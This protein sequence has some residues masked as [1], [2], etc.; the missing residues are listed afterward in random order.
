MAEV[1]RYENGLRLVV[2]TTPGV[3]SVAMGIFVGVGSIRETPE[4]NG[5]SHFTEHM[6]FKGTD[7]LTPFEVASQFEDKGAMVNAFTSKECTCYF[8]KAVDDVADECFGMLSDIFFHSDFKQVE[9]DKERKVIIEE[10]NMGE[11][12]PADVCYDLIAEAVY[13]SHSLALPIL[14][15][16]KNVN[17]FNGDDIRAF[18]DRFY[19][20]DNLVVA[21]SGS[22][23]TVQADAIVRKYMLPQLK[24]E[25]SA[26][27]PIA[28]CDS[29]GSYRERIKDFEQ[30]NIAIAFP[31]I[32]F[33]HPDTMTQSALN[34]L[35]GGGMS[36]RL[37]QAIREQRGLAY[38]VYSSASAYQNN[39]AF[40]VYLNITAANTAQ[41]VAATKQ[42]IER[43]L[44]DGIDADEFERARAQLKSALVFGQE[45]SQ[46][47]MMAIGKLMAVCDEVYDI[48]K[49]L[50]E[51]DELTCDRVYAFAKQ[52]F[53]FDHVSA[54]Y[55]GKP[56]D[57]DIMGILKN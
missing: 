37:F 38:S 50:A 48:N 2:D 24:A 28:H 3:R 29:V 45:S 44:R 26:L 33:N 49:R 11:D 39:G 51:I 55:V 36:S 56:F 19:R 23:T 9:T 15:P 57:A 27:A 6:M 7:T 16:K 42:E 35:L 10:I 12:D 8:F 54:A 20:P 5:L 4:W 47:V 18:I 41:A 30:S 21:V 1:I 32:P 13:G 25:R 46:S 22:L 31:S 52:L 53:D 14:G 40:S 43:L 17:R 34:A